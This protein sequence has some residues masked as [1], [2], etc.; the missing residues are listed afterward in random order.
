MKAA[1]K[2]KSLQ[3]TVAVKKRSFILDK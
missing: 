2:K 1:I 3:K